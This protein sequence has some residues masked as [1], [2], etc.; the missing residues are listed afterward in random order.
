MLRRPAKLN[1]TYNNRLIPRTSFLIL[2][3]IWNPMY[4]MISIHIGNEFINSPLKK[5]LS[6][7]AFSLGKKLL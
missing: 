1:M 4:F 3:Q 6:F 7:I 5:Y 2:F